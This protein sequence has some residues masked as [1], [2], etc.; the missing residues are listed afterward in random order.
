MRIPIYKLRTKLKL[1]ITLNYYQIL[2]AL[3]S[4]NR[5]QKIMEQESDMKQ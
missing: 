4:I 5:K 2:L 3:L 1:L